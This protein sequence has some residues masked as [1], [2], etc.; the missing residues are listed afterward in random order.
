VPH[1]AENALHIYTDGSQLSKP[2]RQG[3]IGFVFI[4]LRQGEEAEEH[5]AS[6][7]GWKGATN[8]Q[9]ELKAG[10]EALKIATGK[11]CPV[12]LEG[13]RKIVIH[14]D[15]LYF[16]DNLSSAIYRWSRNGWKGRDDSP[17]RNVDQWK[18]L[19]SLAKRA[20]RMGMRLELDWVKGHSKD[21]HN[22]AADRLA[23]ASARAPSE[24]VLKPVK[25]RRKLSLRRCEP[26][27][28]SLNG[29]V[30]TIRIVVDQYLPA[31]HK[32]FDYMYEVVDEESGD[33]QLVDKATG[34][35]ALEAGHVYEVRFSDGQANPRVVEVLQE[36]VPDEE[37]PEDPS[38]GSSSP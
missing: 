38:S 6:P 37:S 32:C 25:I 13:L 33:F 36:I 3:G 12:S 1:L 26:G 28:I 10:I 15:S 8:Q 18:E 29:Q 17:I 21:P 35:F 4:A 7:P 23:K 14:S 11:H 9:M 24:R 5:E 19:I 31:P 30:E 34:D 2:R 20:D 16:V 22:K 27:C